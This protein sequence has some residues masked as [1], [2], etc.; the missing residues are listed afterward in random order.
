MPLPPPP[1]GAGQGRQ[2]QGLHT[3]GTAVAC[4]YIPH[5]LAKSI[6]MEGTANTH[7]FIIVLGEEDLCK[8]P[9][10]LLH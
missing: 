7:Y 1:R 5:T 4:N 10:P 6:F 3:R 9:L 8:L 2:T